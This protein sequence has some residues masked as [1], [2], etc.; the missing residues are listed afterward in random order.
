MRLLILIILLI[1]SISC[2]KYDVAVIG[3]GLSGLTTA[4][5]LLQNKLKVIVIEGDTE[6]GG[7]T[8][9]ELYLGNMQIS[10]GGTWS[11]GE[12]TA[13]MYL[14]EEIDSVPDILPSKLKYFGLY[15]VVKAPI[16]LIKLWLMGYEVSYNYKNYWE[17]DTAE[18]LDNYPLSQ[19]L[20]D[21]ELEYGETAIKAVRDYLIIMETYPRDMNL[22]TLFA[23]QYIY[24]RLRILD[25]NG[26]LYSNGVYRWENGTSMFINKLSQ[27]I[28]S[29]GGEI[30][31]NTKVD[32]IDWSNEVIINNNI[33]V[34]KVVIAT[35]LKASGNIKYVPSLPNVYN[36]LFESSVP[37]DDPS[38]QIILIYKSKWW[39]N[40]G[41]VILPDPD[42]EN[43][44]IWGSMFDLTPK[45]DTRGVLRILV[46]SKHME[47]KTLE[48]T[49]ASVFT[50]LKSFYLD[51]MIQDKIENELLLFD[52]YN[53][54]EKQELIPSV[55]Y[56][57]PPDGTLF[58]YGSALRTNINNKIYW[59]GAERARNGQHWMEGA[60]SRGNEVAAEIL[61]TSHL[62]WM[63]S[64]RSWLKYFIKPI[65]LYNI[66]TLIYN[67]LKIIYKI[68]AVIV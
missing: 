23:C 14:A 24:N 30:L 17:A 1:R 3:G 49:K 7:R 22:S 54:K 27:Q 50:Y 15:R 47:N 13:T 38:H 52:C 11:L 65:D 25:D 4:Y 42:T 10:V 21:Q 37:F 62:V 36:K 61:N 53:W 60:I 41:G 8:R 26:G 66:L 34:K 29:L 33:R 19:W 67:F 18:Y 28:K 31:T 35:S 5:R 58:K 9:S 55:N 20:K 64:Y 40:E 44:E 51:S 45:D 32:T 48:Q 16:L 43:D 6:L 2:T 59:A 39:I 63:T 57:Y 46:W 56:I 68:T 12:N